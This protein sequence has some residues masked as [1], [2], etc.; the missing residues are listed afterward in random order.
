M[1]VWDTTPC[2]GG[3]WDSCPDTLAT[4]VTG[5]EFN[6]AT[7]CALMETG[8]TAQT[9]LVAA[10]NNNEVRDSPTNRFIVALA[11]NPHQYVVFDIRDDD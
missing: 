8:R 7:S 6:P 9:Y 1:N 2:T 11:V 4:K 10:T 3:S 5:S